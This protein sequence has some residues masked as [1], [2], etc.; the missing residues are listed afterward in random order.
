MEYTNPDTTAYAAL[1]KAIGVTVYTIGV[2]PASS[3][4]EIKDVATNESNFYN[5]TSFSSLEETSKRLEK[6]VCAGKYVYHNTEY[7]V[8][9]NDDLKLL[10]NDGCKEESLFSVKKTPVWTNNI[11]CNFSPI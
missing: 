1:L 11:K 7:H 9:C 4:S 2:Y 5:I 8:A 10:T 3:L 6:A